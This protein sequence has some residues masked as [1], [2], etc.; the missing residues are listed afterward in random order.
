[1]SMKT[2]GIANCVGSAVCLVLLSL[3]AAANSAAAEA[4]ANL[5]AR[6]GFEAAE[7]ALKAA[8]HPFEP[9]GYEVDRQ[10]KHTGNQSI[11]LAVTTTG[12]AKGASYS[13]PP[14][15]IK[16]PGSILVSA[17]SKAQGVSRS[18]DDAYAIYI[19]VS[20]ADGTN[21]HQVTAPFEPGTHDWQYASVVVPVPKAVA[22]FSIHLL[23]RG[24]HMGTAWFDDVYAAAFPENGTG[25]GAS[26][27]F[28]EEIPKYEGSSEAYEIPARVIDMRR[29]LPGLQDKTATLEALVD[30]AESKGLDA[31][32][33]RVSLSVAK[34]F[35]PLLAE[36]ASLTGSASWPKARC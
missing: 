12:V 31:S 20:Y 3:S 36:D 22:R 13:L 24:N 29:R 2:R 16:M 14:D 27:G 23:F 25:T 35:T 19:D 10:E 1:M 8:W 32:L 5:L 9:G 7:A 4:P 33:P 30:E 18:K 26:P 21:L 28:R 15:Q 34:V 17:W 11:K 6:P